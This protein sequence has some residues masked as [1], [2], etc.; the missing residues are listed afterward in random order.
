M[1]YKVIQWASGTV[2]KHALRAVA[3]RADMQLVGMYVFSDNKAGQDAGVLADIGKLGVKATSDLDA[4]V[5]MDADVV[6]H[7]S[8]PSLVYGNDTTADVDAFCALLASGKNVITTVGYMYPKIY[9]PELTDRLDAACRRGGTTFHST[10]LNPGWLGDVLPL[11][12]SS[13]SRRIE[14][15]YVR[16]ISNFQYYP[17]P[18]IMFDMMGFGK[19]PKQFQQDAARYAF[20][21]SG[22]FRENVQMIADGLGVVLDEISEHTVRELAGADLTTAA[23]IVRKG[24]VAGQHWEWAGMAQGRKVIVHETV[25]RMHDSVAPHWPTGEH[26]V[27]IEGEPRMHVNF[28]A[29]WI[30]DGLQG[31]AMHAV[32]AIPYVCAAPCGVKTFLDLPWMMGRGTVRPAAPH[33][34]A[35]PAKPA[36]P[37]SQTKSK[38]TA[39]AKPSAK[40]APA[41][42]TTARKS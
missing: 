35:K 23:G 10:G 29:D 22:L 40:P 25:W 33:K 42:P 24:T 6:L 28:A 26:S 36:K 16:E 14:Q 17:S 11:T 27:T 31:T 5:A 12:M 20:W 21:L 41:R 7:T 18:E 37:G 3:E 34:P 30:S 15:V 2:G 19:T 8:L 32:N 9:G 13:L 4:I 1:P 38:P 39:K